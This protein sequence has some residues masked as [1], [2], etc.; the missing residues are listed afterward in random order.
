MRRLPWATDT[1]GRMQDL[2]LTNPELDFWIDARIREFD[3]R[4]LAVADLA[5]TPVRVGHQPGQAT[6]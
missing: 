1:M 6:S 4:W 5:G 2:R 3:G